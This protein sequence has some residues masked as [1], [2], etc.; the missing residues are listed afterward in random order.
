MLGGEQPLEGGLVSAGTRRARLRDRLRLGS[1]AGRVVRVSVLTAVVVLALLGGATAL[2]LYPERVRPEPTATRVPAPE[3]EPPLRLDRLPASQMPGAREERRA[4]AKVAPVIGV[5]TERFSGAPDA[6]DATVDVDGDKPGEEVASDAEIRRQLAAL[7]RENARIEAALRGQGPASGTG[8]LIWPVRGGSI[9]SPFGQRWG[10]LHAGVDIGV[11]TGSAVYA[12]DSG[13]VAVSGTVGGYGNYICIQHTRSLST[14][15]GHNS[16]LGVRKGESVRK[17]AVIAKSGC[18]GR[19]Y[20]PHVHFETRVGG[21][22][23]N[24]MRY[25]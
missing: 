9:T 20:G 17:G 10:R 1:A 11:P 12:A 4:P 21:S 5:G 14:C 2:W 19:C 23:V 7:E 13:R 18:T 15:Y 24:P 3:P 8:R 6:A 25:Y 16:R 22:P